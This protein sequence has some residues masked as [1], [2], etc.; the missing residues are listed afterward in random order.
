MQLLRQIQE[1]ER[2]TSLWSGHVI[3]RLAERSPP[4]CPAGA[5]SAP[6]AAQNKARINATCNNLPLFTGCGWPLASRLDGRTSVT[7][8]RVPAALKLTHKGSAA[9]SQVIFSVFSRSLTSMYLPFS[10]TSCQNIASV[11]KILYSGLYVPCFHSHFHPEGSQ[12]QIVKEDLHRTA[13]KI[14]NQ[15]EDGCKLLEFLQSLD[16]PKGINFRSAFCF[17]L[18]MSP[19][20][21]W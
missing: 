14:L 15:G 8:P 6:A 7:V 10:Q 20:L 2:G 18:W 21:P 12:H 3:E 19:V 11:C 1:V 17:I 16:P 13:G 4:V 9:S 5:F